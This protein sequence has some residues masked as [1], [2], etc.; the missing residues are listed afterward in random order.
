MVTHN[1]NLVINSDADQVII[2]DA[3]RHINGGLPRL[4]Y[5][6]SGLDDA[7]IRQAV[8]EILE[9]GEDAFLERARRLRVNLER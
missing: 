6:G 7:A 1:A 4:T 3:S 5:R 2:A 9:G 8:C